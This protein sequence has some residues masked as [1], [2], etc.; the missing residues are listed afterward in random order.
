MYCDYLVGALKVNFYVEPATETEN[1]NNKLSV[2]GMAC[3]NQFYFY[4]N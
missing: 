3:K 1:E 4:N 2:W